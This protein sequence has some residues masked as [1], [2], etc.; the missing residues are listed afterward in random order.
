MLK[1][2][3]RLCRWGKWNSLSL[4]FSRSLSTMVGIYTY[5]SNITCAGD[6]RSKRASARSLV[7]RR[8]FA[9][10]Q[11]T[12]HSTVR[13]AGP[14]LQN[15]PLTLHG[16]STSRRYMT[17]YQFAFDRGCHGQ[18]LVAYLRRRRGDSSIPALRRANLLQ[19]IRQWKESLDTVG[20]RAKLS[21]HQAFYVLCFFCSSE[22][23]WTGHRKG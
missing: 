10:P 11:T 23:G 4:A 15:R 14:D 12:A 17:S 13:A 19:P 3:A 16:I 6:L 18:A 20:T 1:W 2:R 21:R 22:L 7:S 8:H 9:G 5:I